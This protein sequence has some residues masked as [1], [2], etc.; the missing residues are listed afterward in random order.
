MVTRHYGNGEVTVVWEP[1]K[2]MHSGICFRGLPG[3]FDPRR[4]PWVDLSKAETAAIIA[5][6]KD[7]PSGA[8][9]L[10]EGAPKEE[11]TTDENLAPA[12]VEV[13]ANGPLR[14]SGALL[15]KLPDGSERAMEKCALCRC[16][17]SKNKPFCDGSHKT[18]GFTG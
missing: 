6:V 1:K 17:G 7:C 5:Q 9:S 8:L 15:I 13:S 2:C 4:R 10:A 3:V 14:L 16:G 18:N 11:A 12:I